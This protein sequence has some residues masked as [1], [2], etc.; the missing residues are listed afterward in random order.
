MY[1]CVDAAICLNVRD[2]CG[3]TDS[4]LSLS[5]FL[6]GVDPVRRCGLLFLLI[7]T[8]TDTATAISTP[9]TFRN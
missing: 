2:L 5:L 3:L 4:T 8:V 6:P 1:V 9:S 7:H